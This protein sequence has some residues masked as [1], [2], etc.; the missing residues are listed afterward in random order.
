MERGSWYGAWSV[1]A[2]RQGGDVSD[3]DGRA[4]TRM[5]D[6]RCGVCTSCIR[7]VDGEETH[8]EKK[9]QKDK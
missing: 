4:G 3:D 6:G 8:D 2:N 9:N 1:E 7:R 5:L